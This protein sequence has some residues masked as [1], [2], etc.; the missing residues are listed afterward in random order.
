MEKINSMKKI[1]I[2]DG[3]VANPGDLDWSALEKF[4][5]LTVYHRTPKEMV[6]ERAR[7]AEI[8]LTNKCIFDSETI[9][10]LPKLE[11]I[12]LLATGYNNIDV[13]TA[14]A[15]HITVCNAVG[16]SSPAVAQHVFALLLELTNRVGLHNESVQQNEW[17]NSID[18]S[19][20]KN[21]IIELQGKTLGIYGLGKI[22][23][24]VAKIGL[25]FG[26]KVIATRRNPDKPTLDGV[27]LV[28][29]EQLLAESDVL[30]LHAPLSEYNQYF[31]NADRLAKMK[32]TAFL[33]NTGRGGLVH[34][35]DLRVA[36]EDGTIAG[37]GLDVLSQEPPS[38]NHILLNIPN[39]IITPHH[40]WAA[41]AS[42][43][44]LLKIVF[45][46]VKAFINGQPQNVCF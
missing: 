46:N 24:A 26:M 41:K 35:A 14:K 36:L 20:Q 4:G 31:I 18:W 10:Q 30:T 43:K 12:G 39:C 5:T 33:I 16:Y 28:D 37:A 17:A 27:I 22:G 13:A 45:D 7:A 6:I 21:P 3:Y 44:R 38:L 29:E 9:S 23:T 19:Y 40:A 42:R 34:E 8:I 15:H 1:V 11:Y 32:N 25:A 2:L